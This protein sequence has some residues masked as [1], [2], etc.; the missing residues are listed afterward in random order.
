VTRLGAGNRGSVLDRDKGSSLL[1]SVLIASDP[2]PSSPLSNGH[3]DLIPQ[4][5]SG[6]VVKLTTHLHQMRMLRMRAVIPPLPHMPSWYGSQL[7]TG[8][9]LPFTCVYHFFQWPISSCTKIFSVDH[10]R[11]WWWRRRKSPKRWSLT[12]HRRGWSENILVYL[13]AVKDS[14]LAISSC[15]SP[16]T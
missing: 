14:N 15:P 8:T 1:N 5:Q 10:V 3:C 13:F 2:F 16:Y 11:S 4:R 12:Q 6:R 7:S 9:T